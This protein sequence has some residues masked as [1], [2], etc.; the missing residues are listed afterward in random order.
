MSVRKSPASAK[1]AGPSASPVSRT[2]KALQ[3][4][5]LV[6][7]IAVTA[8]SEWQLALLV[9]IHP[10]VAPLFPVAVDTYVVASVRAGKGRDIAASLA[11]MGGCQV[12]AHLLST[13]SVSTSIPLVAAVSLLIPITV[14][15]V[16][17]LAGI[18]RTPISTGAST[19]APNMTKAP[20][21]VAR[22]EA[23]PWKPAVA[24]WPPALQPP[25]VKAVSTA[26]TPRPEAATA[27]V[28]EEPEKAPESPQKH[29]ADRIVRALYD[30]LG[31]K[32]PSTRHIRQALADANLPNSDGSCRQ[33]RLRVE[34][35]EPELKELPP[36]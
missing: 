15:R 34:Q 7:G 22:A 10:A 3:A 16:H 5:A 36:A 21:N 2:D 4:V 23:P 31:R 1:V 27:R 18:R 6:A 20:V 14:W 9:G 19:V 32:R 12:S 33:A 26:L 25:P 28:P 17:A 13:N 35:E 8:Y 11:V 30:E 29:L 24:K